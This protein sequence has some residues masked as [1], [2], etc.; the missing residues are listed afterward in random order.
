[1]RDFANSLP[2]TVTVLD[3]HALNP[4]D[5]PFPKI[6]GIASIESWPRSTAF[7]AA[8][9]ALNADIVITNK[10]PL[11]AA[12]IDKLPCLKFIAVTATGYNVVDLAAA[13]SRDIPVSNVPDY[14][15]STV[16]QFTMS[17]IL[18]L[19]HR[20]ETHAQSVTA[21]EWVSSPDWCYWKTPQVELQ[22]RILGIVGFGRIGKRVAELGYAFG[23]KVVYASQQRSEVVT[24]PA[25]QVS[26]EKLFQDADVVS[27]HCALTRENRG[28]V[29]RERLRS[30]KRTAFLINTARG[31]LV[32]EADLA[33][34][35]REQT[36][37]GAAVDVLSEEPPSPSNPLLYAPNCLITP[38]IAWS[39][40]SARQRIL[41]AT[42]ANIGAFLSGAPIN[43]VN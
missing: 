6:P 31:Q 7:Q 2:L 42:V 41:Q 32:E 20:V 27:L 5:N 35:L 18:A 9:R 10:T 30:M 28:F 13:R 14:G 29:N 24:I 22:N 40:L 11:S 36:I 43:V 8:E 37:A 23:M 38:H 16:A 21:G 25:E 19:C 12:M 1:M 26:L 3:N 17:L 39:T 33:A 4:G 34:A 15:T